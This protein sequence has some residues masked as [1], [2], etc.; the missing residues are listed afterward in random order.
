MHCTQTSLTTVGIF[1]LAADTHTACPQQLQT[2]STLSTH[3]VGLSTTRLTRST[4]PS[5]PPLASAG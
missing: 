4:A 2:R 5:S 3:G 1:R